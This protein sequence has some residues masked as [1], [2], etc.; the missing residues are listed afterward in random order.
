MLQKSL[1]YAINKFGRFYKVPEK[2]VILKKIKKLQNLSHELK[3]QLF[4][5]TIFWPKTLT[6][7]AHM[8]N[9]TE[10]LSY[11]LMKYITCLLDRG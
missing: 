6:T 9:E 2:I 3:Q 10:L 4:Y 8:A 11:S 7:V 1:G 5:Q